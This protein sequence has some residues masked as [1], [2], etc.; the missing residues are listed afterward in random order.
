MDPVSVTLGTPQACQAPLQ[1]QE[2]KASK[3]QLNALCLPRPISLMTPGIWLSKS[4]VPPTGDQAHPPL[5][6]PAQATNPP[7]VQ[8]LETEYP[9]L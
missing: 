7:A 6:R 5:W 4:F 1:S 2:E 9:L 8:G 3:E